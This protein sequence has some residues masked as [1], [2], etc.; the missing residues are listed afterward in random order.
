MELDL[1]AKHHSLILFWQFA[2]RCLEVSERWGIISSVK[3]NSSNGLHVPFPT[4]VEFRI[5]KFWSLSGNSLQHFRFRQMNTFLL[6][7]EIRP[8]GVD[9]SFFT[10]IYKKAQAWDSNWAFI[11]VPGDMIKN[12][13]SNKE[14][15]DTGLAILWKF[16]ATPVSGP[17]GLSPSKSKNL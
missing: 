5:I 10:N 8:L 9:F 13:L 1:N 4:R 11:W 12:F 16:R 17:F 15:K 2:P 3:I 6:I 14:A 7:C